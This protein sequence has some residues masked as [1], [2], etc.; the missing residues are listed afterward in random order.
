MSNETTIPLATGYSIN[1]DTEATHPYALH[2]GPHLEAP[3]PSQGV[4]LSR[5]KTRQEAHLDSWRE[6]G[7]RQQ[8]ETFAALYTLQ[9]AT[10][11]V[12]KGDFDLATAWGLLKEA[13]DLSGAPFNR[14]SD[15]MGRAAF[16]RYPPDG[17]GP[18]PAFARTTPTEGE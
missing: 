5:W 17:Y 8:P 1:V 13:A 4:E 18:E 12:E 11:A 6:W 3:N 7:E 16:W 9:E 10:E 2:C 15:W 14:W